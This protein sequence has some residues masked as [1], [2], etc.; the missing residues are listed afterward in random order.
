LFKDFLDLAGLKFKF[1]AHFGYGS[2]K[3]IIL[4]KIDIDMLELR[5]TLLS[6]SWV[7]GS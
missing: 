5:I 2:L 4:A 1:K 6:R 3:V 7:M